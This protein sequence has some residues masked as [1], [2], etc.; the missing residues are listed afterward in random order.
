MCCLL[1]V[2]EIVS[3]LSLTWIASKHLDH[4]FPCLSVRSKSI[5]A[6]LLY[7]FGKAQ[8]V[9]TVTS[10]QSDGRRVSGHLLVMTGEGLWLTSSGSYDYF[11]LLKSR[12]QSKEA[13]IGNFYHVFQH[14]QSPTDP[15]NEADGKVST[16]APILDFNDTYI[17]LH[18]GIVGTPTLQFY[19]QPVL[20]L[21]QIQPKFGLCL[22][23]HELQYLARNIAPVHCH[24]GP[25]LLITCS[26][27][28]IIENTVL[29]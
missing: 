29:F 26:S 17:Q 21:S 22:G 13:L 27:V 14:T 28:H 20:N 15:D 8:L 24:P 3:R 16:S 4:V 25:L 23:L 7:I 9:G 12:S 2:S 19:W 11:F 18:S 1:G 10:L 5:C 6:I